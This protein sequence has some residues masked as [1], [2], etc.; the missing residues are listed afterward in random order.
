MEESAKSKFSLNP[1]EQTYINRSKLSHHSHYMHD[2]HAHRIPV[3][4]PEG[5]KPLVRT[6][7]RREGN[8]KMDLQEIGCRA[9]IGL[10]W[11]RRWES[12]G[13]L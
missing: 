13:F 6:R 12:G 4:E 11:I 8:I 10:I 3:W 1:K 5:K 7:Y 2:V 9:W